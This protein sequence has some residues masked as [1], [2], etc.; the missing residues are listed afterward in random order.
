[1]QQKSSSDKNCASLFLWLCSL[2]PFLGTNLSFASVKTSGLL[3]KQVKLYLNIKCR[4]R[5]METCLSA[6]QNSD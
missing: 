6:Y 1:M 2:I 3:S 5:G 4:S